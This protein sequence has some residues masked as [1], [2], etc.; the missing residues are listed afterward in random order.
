MDDVASQSNGLRP[1]Q[2]L[3]IRMIRQSI[4]EGNSRLV[5][6]A[7]CSFGK[8]RVAMEI[9]KNTAKNGKLGIFIC[10]RV[11]LVDQALEEFDRAG[12]PCGVIQADHWRTNPGA[13][14]QI[15]SIQTIAKRRYKP[16]F[17]VAVV[18]EC[19]T[20]YQTLTELMEDYSKS[21]FIG[22]SATPYSKGLGLHYSDLVVPITPSQLLDKGYLCPVRYFGGNTANLKGVKNK[23]LSTGGT[24]YDP[25]SLSAA[26]EKDQKLVG[27]I[28]LNFKKHG[29]GQTIAFCPSIK[30]SRKLVDMLNES[31]IGAE[32]IDGY[33]DQE[34]RRMIF[35]AHDQGEFQVLS[36]S[37]LLNTGY[38]APQVTTLIDC[39]P[40]KSKIAFIQRAGRIMRTCDGKDEAIYLDHA[41]NIERHGFPEFLVPES[42]HD[43]IKEYGENDLV[44]K[45]RDEPNPSV[46]PQCYQFYIIRCAC[47]YQKPSKE[48]LSS[49]GQELKELKKVNKEMSVE[50]KGRWLGEFELY[51]EKKHYKKGWAAW[52]YKSKFGV[53]PN[54]VSAI[55][56]ESVSTEVSKHITHIN[57]R[58]AKRVR[59]HIR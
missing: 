34:D 14:I 28:I 54:K 41:G 7:P 49:D 42:L 39:F 36:C 38:D 46:C 59:S 33:M 21:I 3:S 48:V 18:D 25:K 27:D 24:D 31:G 40:T 15:A 17:H 35:E 29:K 11:K 32:H 58:K 16:L 37:R 44:K 20:H 45:E 51:A 55:Y 19:H 4:R 2:D 52:M 5:L 26:V 13:Q 23:R 8:T 10:D 6:A 47:G 43:G 50:E 30:Q 1:H 22:L 12:I 57:I 9:L 56:A 53:W